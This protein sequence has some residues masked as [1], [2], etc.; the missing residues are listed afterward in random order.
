VPTTETVTGLILAGGRSS[1]MQGIDKGL[2]QLNQQPM[3]VHVIQRLAPQVDQIIINTN[4]H[5]EKYQ[6]FGF[7]VIDDGNLEFNGPLAGIL[8]GLHHIHSGYLQS[9]SCDSP[10]LPLNL[11][12]RLKNAIGNQHTIAVPFDGHRLQPTFSLIHHQ[13]RN[14]LEDYLSQGNRKLQSWIQQQQTIEVDFSD[15][16]QAFININTPQELDQLR[17]HSFK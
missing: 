8:A 2:I 11:T 1:R 3:I 9:A 6:H 12:Q 16:A 13:L 14:S 5:K 15:Q 7:P 10:Q 17:K 4:R